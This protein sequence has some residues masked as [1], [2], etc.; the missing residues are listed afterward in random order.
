MSDRR[1]TEQKNHKKVNY[2]K[3][4]N[5]IKKMILSKKSP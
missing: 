2:K 5:V 1:Y 3:R 4:R